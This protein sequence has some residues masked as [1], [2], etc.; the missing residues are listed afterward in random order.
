MP[1]GKQTAKKEVVSVDI[2][3]TP[4]TPARV[5]QIETTPRGPER[6]QVV[7]IR[8]LPGRKTDETRAVTI[9]E[10]PA[11]KT[12]KKRAV[13]IRESPAEKTDKRRVVTTRTLQAVR[14]DLSPTDHDRLEHCANE[15]GVSMSAYASQAVLAMIQSDERKR[16]AT[17]ST[18]KSREQ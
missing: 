7:T 17:T 12:K 15:R 6:I 16:L 5:V 1:P 3:P 8:N 4:T 2:L 11:Q 18:G 14:L 9:R 10:L 13:A